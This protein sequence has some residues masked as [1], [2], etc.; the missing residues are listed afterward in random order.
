MSDPTTANAS[1]ASDEIRIGNHVLRSRLIV[2]TG[3]YQ[4]SR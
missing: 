3:K 1:P 4:T 2:G